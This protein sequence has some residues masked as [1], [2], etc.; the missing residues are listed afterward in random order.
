MTTD[1]HQLYPLFMSRLADCIFELDRNDV[2]QLKRAKENQLKGQS[3]TRVTDADII[4]SISKREIQIHCRRHTRG[5]DMTVDRISRL[6]ELF[7]GEGGLDTMG[8][9]LLD[10][11]RIWRL[12]DAAKK[13]VPCIQDPECVPLYKVTGKVRKGGV[14]LHEYRCARGSTSLESFHCHL[15]RFVPGMFSSIYS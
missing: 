7:S 6:L 4:H 14:L 2:Q 3:R 13:H 9:P 5:M 15:Q 8:V 12:W 11:R 1:A 10:P